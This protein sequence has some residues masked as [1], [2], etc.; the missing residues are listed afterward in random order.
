MKWIWKWLD[1]LLF[2]Q[3]SN[4][5]DSDE[6]ACINSLCSVNLL[7]KEKTVSSVSSMLENSKQKFRGFYLDKSLG[8]YM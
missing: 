2:W 4:D 3:I 6:K 8:F 5:L 1:Q 7:L